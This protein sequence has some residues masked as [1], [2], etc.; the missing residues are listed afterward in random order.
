MDCREIQ[1]ITRAGNE[2]FPGK[3]ENFTGVYLLLRSTFGIR[4]VSLDVQQ[5]FKNTPVL[6][7]FLVM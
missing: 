5:L 2:H 1:S 4:A 3:W 6:L 7:R